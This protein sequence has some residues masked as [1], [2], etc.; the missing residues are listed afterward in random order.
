MFIY[1]QIISLENH[2]QSKYIIFTEESSKAELNSISNFLWNQSIYNFLLLQSTQKGSLSIYSIEPFSKNN[3]RNSEIKQVP[4]NQYFSEK[5]SDFHKCP[6]HVAY[7]NLPLVFE[8]S[9]N[10]TMSG[11]EY[12]ILKIIAEKMNFFLNISQPP[13]VKPNVP[14]LEVILNATAS[15][16]YDIA[17]GGLFYRKER[18]K[19]FSPPYPHFSASYIVYVR[20]FKTPLSSLKILVSP[21]KFWT[22]TFAEISFIIV[23]AILY[24]S[25]R[26]QFLDNLTLTTALALS[27]PLQFT[28]TKFSDRIL[29][30]SWIVFNLIFSTLYHAEF[31]N[32]LLKDEWEPLPNFLTDLLTQNYTLI[33]NPAFFNSIKEVPEIIHIRKTVT[34]EH[35]LYLMDYVAKSD[36]KLVSAVVLPY[37]YFNY[38]RSDH[39]RFHI[40]KDSLI[41]FPFSFYPFKNS[42]L[43]VKMD[44]ILLKLSSFGIISKIANWNFGKYEKSQSSKT[45][46]TFQAIGLNKLG[47]IF[48]VIMILESL[49]ITIFIFE[50]IYK[51]KNIMKF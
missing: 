11:F 6:V 13:E 32:K 15:K 49:A 34:A 51:R 24:I 3:C 47:G 9:P 31:Y 48:E 21:F 42:F 25:R 12:T 7:I 28:N 1:R 37:F 39:E 33:I 27:V 43:T 10:Q 46:K 14:L 17:L 41:P 45:E 20:N 23:T 4:I 29:L 19:Y 38:S 16:K 30:G 5:F 36:E 40:L 35:G 2:I 18:L 26:N 50:I 44:D 8:V 22:W